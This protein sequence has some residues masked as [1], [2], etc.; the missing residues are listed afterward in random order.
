[1]RKILR[2][3]LS[4]RGGGLEPLNPIDCCVIT[5]YAGQVTLIKQ[6]LDENRAL[7]DV[8]V[9]SVDG[10]QGREK[11][12]VVVSA[13]RANETG[14]CGFLSD[15][16]RLNVTLTRAKRGVIVVG[17]PQTLRC[18]EQCWGPW[19]KWAESNGLVYGTKRSVA[20]GDYAEHVHNS[21]N[22]QRLFGSGAVPKGE[23][24]GD[25]D[26]PKAEPDAW[27]DDE[28][29]GDKDVW[30]DSPQLKPTA[31]PD[32]PP[33]PGGGRFSLV[34]PKQ[35]PS[36]ATLV[37]PKTVVSV[38][39]PVRRPEEELDRHAA[40]LAKLDVDQEGGVEQLLVAARKRVDADG[41]AALIMRV[42]LTKGLSLGGGAKAVI[43]ELEAL[44]P[45][46]SELTQAGTGQGHEAGANAKQLSV[47]KLCES[48]FSQEGGLAAAAERMSLVG[49]V[50]PKVLHALYD[51]DAVE[52]ESFN[53]W[54]S[55]RPKSASKGEAGRLFE[56]QAGKFLEWLGDA[57]EDSTDGEEDDE[58]E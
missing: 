29:D 15:W 20:E 23:P 55:T 51:A 41:V 43:A 22:M 37:K 28:G 5:P 58:D 11:E 54:W 12:L 49:K 4:H 56:E 39:S 52:E 8:E 16:R 13:V 46:I 44:A 1:V 33:S 9:N 47:L 38:A 17:N 10:F 19:L 2:E 24:D 35:K 6:Y 26:T 27:D 53:A 31:A 45:T 21:A 36:S 50:V 18:E 7:Q 57:D 34:S 14:E 32:P 40:Q 30:D 25:W 48:W 3:V 42:A